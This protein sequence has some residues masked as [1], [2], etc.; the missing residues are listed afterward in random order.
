MITLQ[1]LKPLTFR[2]SAAALSPGP[3]QKLSNWAG[4][5]LLHQRNACGAAL[6]QT[7][8]LKVRGLIALITNGIEKR[9]E[10]R[11]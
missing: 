2:S 6:P 4:V 8:P 10:G 1:L 11:P 3:G 7:P 9:K 5:G